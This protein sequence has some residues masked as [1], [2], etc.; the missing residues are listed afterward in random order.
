MCSHAID[1]CGGVSGLP[2]FA[3]AAPVLTFATVLETQVASTTQ[4]TDIK[5]FDLRGV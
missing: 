2:E 3:T 5:P 4:Q 1:L